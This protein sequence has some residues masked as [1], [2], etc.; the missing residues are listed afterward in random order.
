MEIRQIL[1]ILKVDNQKKKKKEDI[2]IEIEHYLCNLR[3]YGFEKCLK[4]EIVNL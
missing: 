1:W 3:N 2:E 4:F